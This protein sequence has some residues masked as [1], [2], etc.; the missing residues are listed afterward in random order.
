MNPSR[1]ALS[2][3]LVLCAFA[4]A[5]VL[6][7]ASTAFATVAPSTSPL[8]G[9]TSKFEGGDANS[10]SSTTTAQ[11]PDAVGNFDWS[12]HP[13]LPLVTLS[14]P[15]FDNPATPAI[16]GDS[17]FIGG[18]KETAPDSWAFTPQLGGVN[19]AKDNVFAAWMVPDNQAANNK[20]FLNLAF[21]RETPTGDTF[22]TFELNQLA[23]SWT[24]SVGTSIPCRVGA[25]LANGNPDPSKP[26][27]ILISYEVTPG[28]GTPVDIKIYQWTSLTVAHVDP[29]D[30][31]VLTPAEF[32]AGD[33]FVDCGKT[34]R[35]DDLSLTNASL[36]SPST[37]QAA[38]NFNKAVSPNNLDEGSPETVGGLNQPATF[39]KG[40]FGEA[41]IDLTA[42]L[43]PPPGTCFAFGQTSVH[44]RSSVSIDSQLQD[45]LSP[46]PIIAGTCGK[47]IIKKVVSGGS[48]SENF[49]FTPSSSLVSGSVDQTPHAIANGTW[50]MGDQG[51]ENFTE[52]APNTTGTYTV[53]ETADPNFTTTGS[54]DDGQTTPSTF[55]SGTFTI[56]VST[57]E[58]VTCTYT[59]TR[60]TGTI[61][62]QKV[63]SPATDPGKFDLAVSQGQT[64]IAS[65]A[66]VGNGGTTGTTTVNTG[67]YS[68]SEAAHSGTSDSD[69]VESSPSCVDAAN[70]NAPVT[71]AAGSV[72]VGYQQ[73]VVC[74]F[75]NTR[76]TG[77]IELQ[78]VL[79]P[80]NDS[81]RFDLTVS[82]GANTISTAPNVGN[83]GTTGS[84][85]VNTGSYHL[86]EA[87]HAGTDDA[88][89]N[90][91]AASCVDAANNNAPVPVTSGDVAVGYQQ[92][93]VC[94]FTNTLIPITVGIDKTGPALAHDGDKL[95]YAISV[96]NPGTTALH[97]VTVTD[98]IKGQT[99][100]C[101]AGGGPTLTGGDANSDGL[102]QSTE[103]WTYSCTYTVQH[104]D[105]DANHNIVNVAS[106][107]GR[108]N[109]GHTVGP[110]TDDA[111]TKVIH[112]AI[113][114]DKTGPATGQAGDKIGYTL[115]V[116]NPGDTPLGDPTV[117]VS[118]AQCNGD[119]VTLLGKGGD[120]SPS[121]LDPG[122][123][124]S[125]SCSVQTA[126]GDTS[127]HNTGSVTGCDTLGGCVDAS[128]T[129]DTTLTQPAQIVSPGRITPGTA[130]LTGP[131]GCV[132]KAFNARV[133]GSKIATVTFVLD[134]K[135]VKK[136]TNKANAT[137]I[138]LR[139][140]PAKF[141]TGVHRLVVNVTFA[142][143]SATKPK[144]IRLSFQRCAKKLVQP[145][146]TG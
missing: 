118:D 101:D 132:A 34:G 22:L 68:L 137:L 109:S 33:P 135:V 62:L 5:L 112:P 75:T 82:Q 94:H 103:T 127:V 9:S 80:A 131:T 124:W 110:I 142:S 32:A 42:L 52:V 141:K 145:R 35:L 53:A 4:C 48:G 46:Q 6:A 28:G 129:A 90:E 20:A 10:A 120:S 67:S 96:T 105:E 40:T 138:Q 26:H 70:A 121:T 30:G 36:I 106:V 78:K 43:Q 65:A 51:V 111:T 60:K 136:V 87:A 3:C 146:F 23:L 86:A 17:S 85:V 11:E 81:G 69:Y 16:E 134:G 13:G 59:N 115:T 139:I 125:Y 89:Y 15:Q 44:S 97:N 128:D 18:N 63:L 113:A 79:S 8:L 54:C 117:K 50:S 119:P 116:T 98:Q 55:S 66:N 133:R 102:L 61:E 12:S 92:H 7:T 37:A 27:D 14:D 24:N 71:V 49:A 130:K 77:T 73:H 38:V 45:S 108:D 1:S 41:S 58:T 47:V 91:S 140:N 95:T 104:S 99:H 25:A 83:G 84:T 76:K 39:G 144:T 64:T 57:S 72:T 114:I 126:L 21:H 29:Q 88:D 2:R 93:V 107:T 100:G 122:D 123:T 19:P 143:G 74:Q 31:H 56:N